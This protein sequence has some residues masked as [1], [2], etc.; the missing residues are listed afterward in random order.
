MAVTEKLTNLALPQKSVLPQSLLY[1]PKITL[2]TFWGFHED[3][4]FFW[5]L[6]WFLV[7]IGSR[8]TSVRKLHYLISSVTGWA[9]ESL[10]GL[11]ITEANYNVAWNLLKSRYDNREPKALR[12]LL[13]SQLLVGITVSSYLL[14]REWLWPSGATWK[15]NLM[16]FQP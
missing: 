2:L 5:D 11:E 10:K 7:Y 13:T 8:F 14:R 15:R 9:R 1:L 12:M 16:A 6:F 4:E 3:W